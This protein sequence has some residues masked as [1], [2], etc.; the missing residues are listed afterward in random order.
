MTNPTS[1]AA[2]AGAA[3]RPPHHDIPRWRRIVGAV[4]LL[5]GVLLVPL[6]LS[7]IWVRNTLLDTDQYVSTVGPLARNS[8]I[9]HGLADRVT[10]ALFADDRVEKRIAEALPPRADV[11]AAPISSGLEGVANQAAL[12]LFQSDRFETLW[13]N[14]NRRAHGAVVKVLTGGGPRVTTTNGTVAIN[15]E[16][17]FTNVKKR[18]DARGITVFDD[19]QLPAKYQSV[20]LIQSKQLEDA[21][22]LVDLLQKAAW[23]LPVLA[24]LCIGG[25]IALARD[26]RRRTMRAGIWVALAVAVQLALL[27]VG[28][29]FYLDAIT[30][31]GVRRGSAGAVWDQLTT[32]LRQGGATMIVLA[33]VV[34]LVAWVVGPSRLAVRIRGMWNNAVGRH[35]DDTGG[36][37]AAFVARSKTGLR[38]AGAAVALLVLILWNHPKPVTVL[39]VAIVYVVYLAVIELV[40][41]SGAAAA[42]GSAAT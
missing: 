8:N 4:L 25:A 2:P 37:F 22:G 30:S 10:T 12:K 7:A 34:A 15:L 29:N 20:V 39:V 32:F 17:I 18:L 11:L 16:Q 26:R 36:A 27:S 5:V 41:R 31:S 40:G 42:P 9:Q 14:V 13:E 23:V 21:Q 35:A 28:R 24:L 1:E 33:L 6:S 3:S 19:V 38:I